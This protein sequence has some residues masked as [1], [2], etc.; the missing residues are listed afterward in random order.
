MS[1]YQNRIFSD[2][3]LM[4]IGVNRGRL[5]SGLRG[6]TLN[7]EK[8]FLSKSLA[9]LFDAVNHI[10]AKTPATCP[11]QSEIDLLV[12]LINKEM[13]L[14]DAMLKKLVARNITKTIQ[15]VCVRAE[16]LICNDGN[17][18]QVIGI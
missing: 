10:F 14:E 12:G 7:Y 17:A 3:R 16:Q 13:N 15:L 9:K 1:S 18:T 8:A 2:G 11:T 6:V 4:K 5:S